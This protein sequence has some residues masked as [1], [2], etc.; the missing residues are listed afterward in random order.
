MKNPAFSPHIRNVSKSEILLQNYWTLFSLITPM[1]VLLAF[2]GPGVVALSA[3]SVAVGGPLIG[4]GMGLGVLVDLPFA[5][6]APRMAKVRVSGPLGGVTVTSKSA[7]FGRRRT[8]SDEEA[9]TCY[10]KTVRR[11][12]SPMLVIKESGEYTEWDEY[13]VRVVRA[14]GKETLL[15]HAGRNRSDARKLADWVSI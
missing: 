10:V 14:E 9:R 13:E 5:F 11:A 4:A 12:E 3:G 2:A 15:W 1:L 8:L 7:W 6:F